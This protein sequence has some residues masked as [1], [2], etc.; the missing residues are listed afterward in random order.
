MIIN[1]YEFTQAFNCTALTG[2]DLIVGTGTSQQYDIPFYGLYNYGE[3][4]QI[5]L[6]SSLGA[7]KQIK[8]F[9]WYFG[10]WTVPYTFTNVEL[11]LAHTTN[12]EFPS[13]VSVGYSTMTLTNLTKVYTGAWNVSSNGVWIYAPFQQ[14]FC[15]NGVNNLMVIA[16]NY[17]GAWTSGY[18]YTQYSSLTASPVGQQYR[19]ANVYQDPSYPANGTA[20]TRAQKVG[21]GRLWY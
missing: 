21:N 12:N 2:L 4:A 3:S 17:D 5:Y 9:G 11:W 10:G 15:Y 8:W 1:P 7:T 19:T 18:G 16:K 6:Q 14:N 13:T 20:M